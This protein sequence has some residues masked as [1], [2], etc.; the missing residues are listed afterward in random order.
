MLE[1]ICSRPIAAAAVAAIRSGEGHHSCPVL[2]WGP[3]A[4]GWSR[5][6]HHRAGSSTAVEHWNAECAKDWDVCKRSTATPPSADLMGLAGLSMARPH[7]R[8][9]SV[10][11]YMD[12]VSQ[13][14]SDSSPTDQVLGHP[15]VLRLRRRAPDDTAS[16]SGSI[17]TLK[18]QIIHG[19]IDSIITEAAGRGPRLRRTLQ[20]AGDHPVKN[21]HLSPAQACSVRGTPRSQSG[22]PR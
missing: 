10:M 19:R 2:M 7:A 12:H 22:Q 9:G 17:A 21:G 3:M 5:W 4:F 8:R 20:C 13:Y 1:T 16:P 14:L 11:A 15:A 18:E 6:T